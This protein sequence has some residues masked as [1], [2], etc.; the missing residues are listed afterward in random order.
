MAPSF[1]QNAFRSSV[2]TAKAMTY[3]NRDS[4]LDAIAQ[5]LRALYHIAQQNQDINAVD[6]ETV[7]TAILSILSQVNGLK[8]QASQIGTSWSPKL[9]T[10]VHRAKEDVKKPKSFL[11]E[12]TQKTVAQ[13]E[14][15][16]KEI[17]RSLNISNPTGPTEVM[18]PQPMLTTHGPTAQEVQSAS[19]RQGYPPRNETAEL[20]HHDDFSANPIVNPTQER[21]PQGSDRNFGS[22]GEIRRPTGHKG[23]IELTYGFLESSTNITTPDFIPNFGLAAMSIGPVRSVARNQ[24][25]AHHPNRRSEQPPAYNSLSPRQSRHLPGLEQPV[26]AHPFGN[27]PPPFGP[28]P[29]NQGIVYPPPHF[30]GNPPVTGDGSRSASS[31]LAL[32]TPQ[33]SAQYPAHY[34]V[35]QVP[36]PAHVG[37][38]YNLQPPSHTAYPALGQPAQQYTGSTAYPTHGSYRAFPVPGPHVGS[39]Y[40][41]PPR[42]QGN[43]PRTHAARRGPTIADASGY[44]ATSGDQERHEWSPNSR[45]EAQRVE[46][47]ESVR[48]ASIAPSVVS[49]STFNTD[50]FLECYMRD[51]AN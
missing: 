20:Q 1:I 27:P 37:G 31:N 3:K 24:E 12:R 35:N 2:W 9:N 13:L 49:A 28:P 43:D 22:Q 6:R 23:G 4:Y 38:S 16:V 45:Y 36:L 19:V 34:P 44:M 39:A 26:P 7:S 40:S 50:E 48:S 21:F 47:A 25:F 8:S 51:N 14:K 18:T 5:E 41:N 17:M 32:N 46:S 42:N 29:S 10:K 30:V 33:G 11:S 15:E